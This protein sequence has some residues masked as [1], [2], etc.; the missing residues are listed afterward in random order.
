MTNILIWLRDACRSFSVYRQIQP[1]WSRCVMLDQTSRHEMAKE[2][3][4]PHTSRTQHHSVSITHGRPS[5]YANDTGL[6]SECLSDSLW[7]FVCDLSGFL[8][9]HS[10]A[11]TFL[12]FRAYIYHIVHLYAL[13][14]AHSH[15]QKMFLP[16]KYPFSQYRVSLL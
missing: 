15:T 14:D 2:P 6:N 11:K 16:R 3:L 9:A 12:L 1:G 8:R 5:L 4:G 7:M 10:Y 13:E